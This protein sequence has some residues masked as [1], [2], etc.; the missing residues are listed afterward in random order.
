MKQNNNFIFKGHI[1]NSLCDK[2]NNFFTE[3]KDKSIDGIIGADKVVD[4][5]KKKC[6][7]IF[8]PVAYFN[9]IFPDYFK[10]LQ[11]VLK[12]YLKKYIY[13]N[14]CYPFHIAEPIKIQRY[15]IDGYY[16]MWH[17]ENV[18]HTEHHSSK[19]HLVFM[20]YLNDAGNAGTEFYYQKEKTKAKKGLTLIWPAA[21]THTHRGIKNDKNSKIEKTIIT[22]WYSFK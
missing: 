9:T 15:P 3:N 18:G 4:Y 12:K 1:K 17:F 21:W 5:D 8:V 20:T 11:N 6:K 14:E 2:I 22:G 7:E 13:C 16:K 10:E 19:R